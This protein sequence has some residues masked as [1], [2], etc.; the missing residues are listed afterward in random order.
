M[1]VLSPSQQGTVS[2][3]VPQ[4]ALLTWRLVPQE[5]IGNWNRTKMGVVITGSHSLSFLKTKCSEPE[6]RGGEVTFVDTAMEKWPSLVQWKV[7]RTAEMV[8]AGL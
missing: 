6:R 4:D 5:V 8:T 2:T 1:T 3:P 7:T